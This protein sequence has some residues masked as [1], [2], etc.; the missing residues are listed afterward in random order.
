MYLYLFIC[1]IARVV[2]VTVGSALG[3]VVC[4]STVATLFW[5]PLSTLI[6]RVNFLIPPMF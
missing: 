1:M 2:L 3:F 6:Y 4:S 5:V